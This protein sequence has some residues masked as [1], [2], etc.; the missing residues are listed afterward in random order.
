MIKNDLS[1]EIKL[2]TLTAKLL[3]QNHLRRGKTFT[4]IVTETLMFI[5]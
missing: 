5:V 4:K 2:K 1:L 3:E